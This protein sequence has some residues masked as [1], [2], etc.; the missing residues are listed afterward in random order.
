[1]KTFEQIRE[2]LKHSVTESVNRIANAHDAAAHAH[3]QAAM[4]K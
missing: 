4:T 2:E 1:M 3:D